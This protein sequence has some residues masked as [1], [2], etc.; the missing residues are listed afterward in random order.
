MSETNKKIRVRANVGGDATGVVFELG[1]DINNIEILSLSIDAEGMYKRHTSDYGCI[2]GRVLANDA[3]G[4]PNARVS[5]FISADNEWL[6]D[7]VMSGLYPYTSISGRNS[8]LLRYNLLPDYQVSDCHQPVGSFPS[9]RVVL[10]DN[11]II[12]VY[13]KFYKYTTRTNGSGDYMLFGVPVGNQTIHVDVDLSDIGFLSQTPRDM[14][15][16]GYDKNQFENSNKFKASTNL[17]GLAQII[18]ENKNVYVYPFGVT[19]IQA[20]TS[21]QRGTMPMR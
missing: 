19:M 18:S 6:F 20:T 12:E 10:D 4:V 2:A 11:N 5:V 14:I 3:V 16:K 21:M 7:S 17:D 13:D 9:K 15:Y 8:D 1:R